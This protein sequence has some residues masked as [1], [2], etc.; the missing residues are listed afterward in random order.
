M[1]FPRIDSGINESR[2]IQSST[3]PSLFAHFPTSIVG[4]SQ[5][6]IAG[7]EIKNLS[8]AKASLLGWLRNC[9]IQIRQQMENV[10]YIWQPLPLEEESVPVNSEFHYVI[11]APNFVFILHTSIELLGAI[12]SKVRLFVQQDNWWIALEP[13]REKC[14]CLNFRSVCSHQGVM[15]Q[16][17]GNW[18]DMKVERKL[19]KLSGEKEASGEARSSKDVAEFDE[20]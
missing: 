14:F 8:L 11:N 16:G 13:S 4:V 17:S 5:Q 6:T 10:D 19:L 9:H 12:K 2:D 20:R 18:Q 3:H 1:N 7:N 15:A